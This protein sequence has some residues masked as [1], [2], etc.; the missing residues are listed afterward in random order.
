MLTGY[1]C[2][3]GSHRSGLKIVSLKEIILY[4]RLLSQKW[5]GANPMITLTFSLF[6][7]LFFASK[8]R[9]LSTV[10]RWD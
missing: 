2:F 4:R 3:T 1:P 8:R 6:R 10:I 5:S 7:E 9:G